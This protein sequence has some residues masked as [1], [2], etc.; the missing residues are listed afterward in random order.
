MK[1]DIAICEGCGK[2]Y[3]KKRKDQRFCKA[4]CREKFISKKDYPVKKCIYCNEEFKP[5]TA[6]QI[7]CSHDCYLDSRK[8]VP[9]NK[10]CAMCGET[11]VT[12]WGNEQY[13]SDECRQF[14]KEINYKMVYQRRKGN[15]KFLKTCLEC[16]E[17]FYDIYNRNKYCSRECAN[18]R[19]GRLQDK[20]KMRKI[21]PICGKEYKSNSK[22]QITR[23]FACRTVRN[24]LKKEGKIN[25]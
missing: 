21:C 4:E 17:P 11:F 22:Y 1:G 15:P 23:S 7:Y 6:R 16:G 13:C 3:V 2:E 9:K 8:S 19:K 25:E 18:R 12:S 14:A 24:R 20:G 5:N 10:K